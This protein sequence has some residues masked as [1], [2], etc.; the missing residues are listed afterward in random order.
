MDRDMQTYAQRFLASAQ[1]ETALGHLKLPYVE[2]WGFYVWR[3]WTM[4]DPGKHG[5]VT[6]MPQHRDLRDQPSISLLANTYQGPET[7]ILSQQPP[8]V[9]MGMDG[10][11]SVYFGFHKIIVGPQ[12]VRTRFDLIGLGSQTSNH[13][14]VGIDGV[15]GEVKHELWLRLA[16]DQTDHVKR[17]PG[18][19]VNL[20]LFI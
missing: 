13:H 7:T 16:H 9:L 1:G 15:W 6:I 20:G 18:Q 19:N 14:I 17:Q 4:S 5:T 8:W 3:A 11:E 12:E 2:D 10:Y